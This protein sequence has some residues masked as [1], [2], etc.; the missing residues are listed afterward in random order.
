MRKPDQK[1]GRGCCRYA[2]FYITRSSLAYVAPVMI[3][4]KALGLDLKAIGGLTSVLPIA[5]GFSKF[6]SGVVGANTSATFLLAGETPAFR[7]PRVLPGYPPD[8]LAMCDSFFKFPLSRSSTKYG[9][10]AKPPI[11]AKACKSR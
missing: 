5:Y 10:R 11:K 7:S 2:G 6:L 1:R 4:D 3:E 9:F 8:L